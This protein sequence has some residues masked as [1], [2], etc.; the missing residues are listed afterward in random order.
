MRK[1]SR[2]ETHQFICYP[3]HLSHSLGSVRAIS[4]TKAARPC[5]VIEIDLKRVRANL[6]SSSNQNLGPEQLF[7]K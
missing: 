3:P 7:T 4:R 5:I 1:P 2:N 6:S